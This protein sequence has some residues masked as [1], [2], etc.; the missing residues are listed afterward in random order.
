MRRPRLPRP[1]LPASDDL[2]FYGGLIILGW[3][4]EQ[5][6]AGVAL[7]GL[8]LVLTVLPLRKWLGL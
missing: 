7:V 1:K 4:V 6:H 2:H 5:Q 8:V 3:G